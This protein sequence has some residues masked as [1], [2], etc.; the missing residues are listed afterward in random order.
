MLRAFWPACVYLGLDGEPCPRTSIRCGP[1]VCA[2][3]DPARGQTFETIAPLEQFFRLAKQT[4]AAGENLV[5][6]DAGLFGWPSG[7]GA[8]EMQEIRF[9]P[10]LNG[11]ERKAVIAF[12]VVHCDEDH[13]PAPVVTEFVSRAS[14][15]LENAFLYS[16]LR[17]EDR[18]KNEFLA[19]LAHELRNPLAPISNAV[20]VMKGMEP[21]DAKVVTWATEIISN[22]LEHMVRI[23]DDLLDVSRIARGTVALQRKPLSLQVVLDRA[24]ETSRPHF[25]ARSQAFAREAS[26]NDLI[27]EGDVVRLTQ[28]VANLLNNASK[29][30]PPGGRINLSTTYKNGVALVTVTDNGEGIEPNLVPR[31]FDLFTQGNSA[32]DRA[33]GGLG[34]GLTLARHLTELHGGSIRCWSGGRGKGARFTVELPASVS[35]EKPASV[36][37]VLPLRRK[38]GMRVLVVDDSIASTESLKIFLEMHGHEVRCAHDGIAALLVARAFAPQVAILDIGLPEMNGYEVAKAIRA[39]AALKDCLLIALSGYGQ[40]DDR[41]KS[42]SAGM[43]HHLIKPADLSAL[44]ELI[45]RHRVASGGDRED[46]GRPA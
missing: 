17:D 27:V 11:E 2:Q 21:S 42:N 9:Y 3:V 44:V 43:D 29:F 39:D 19:M 26:R 23:V 28:V 8:V 22:Q 13:Q 33:Q 24:I 32:L 14:I 10:L 38:R 34:I 15:A 35:Q 36:A 46:A 5:C 16:A 12:G 30:T 37:D 6:R 25:A 7:A 4:L 41:Q 45:S 1:A 40:D 18:R 20:S 31:V